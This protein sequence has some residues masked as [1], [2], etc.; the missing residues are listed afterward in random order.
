MLFRGEKAHLKIETSSTLSEEILNE[1]PWKYATYE[2][3]E[4]LQYRQTERM[5]LSERLR[6]LDDMISLA[7][8]LHKGGKRSTE[9][10]IHRNL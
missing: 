8:E 3:V 2:G 1:D 4:R 5:T 6:A 9:I 7:R 10:L